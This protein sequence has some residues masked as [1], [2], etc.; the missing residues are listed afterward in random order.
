MNTKKSRILPI[1]NSMRTSGRDQPD[2]PRSSRFFCIDHCIFKSEKNSQKF[3][4]ISFHF[5][6]KSC[7]GLN[8]T[9]LTAIVKQRWIRRACTNEHVYTASPAPSL[10]LELD[11]S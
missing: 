5:Y 10:L 6:V 11:S 8:G 2:E 7:P 9:N 4:E 3:L 1:T